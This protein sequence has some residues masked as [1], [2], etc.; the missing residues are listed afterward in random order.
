[1]KT[2]IFFREGLDRQIGDLPVGLV[3]R[4]IDESSMARSAQPG[5]CSLLES[6]KN[7]KLVSLPGVED[8][9]GFDTRHAGPIGEPIER[10]ILEMLCVAHDDMHDHVVTPRNQEGRTNL[11][12]VD[13]IVHQPVDRAAFVLFEADHEERFEPHTERLW[14]Y[15]DMR[16][17]NDAAIA[18]ALNPLMGRG[19]SEA[20]LGG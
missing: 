19:C 9:R 2:K 4:T 7:R 11:G 12:H 14:I 15:V 17:P 6:A 8:D 5:A 1:M 13:D 16:A 20:D 10:E 3:M 18:Q